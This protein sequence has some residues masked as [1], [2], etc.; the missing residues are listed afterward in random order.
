MMLSVVVPIFNEESCIMPFYHALRGLKTLDSCCIV[1]IVFVNDGS[2]DAS[3]KTIE[4][5]QMRDE[6][7]VLVNF[8]R[9]FGKES[10][11]FAGLE[12]AQGDAVIPIDVDLQDPVELIPE[13]VVRWQAGA[14]IVL[15][16]RSDRTSDSFLKRTSARLY[17]QLHNALSRDK[18]EENVGDFRLLSRRSVEQILSLQERLLF[19]KGIMS[20]VGGRVDVVEYQRSPRTAGASKF[21]A[22]RLWN[23][24]LDGITSFSTFPLRVWTYIGM[25]IAGGALGYGAWVILSKLFWGNAVPGYA[26]LMTVMLFLGGVQLIGI[27]V[28]GEYVGRIFLESKGRPR[29]IIDSVTGGRR[30]AG[31]PGHRTA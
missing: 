31:Q 11:L 25:L 20:W 26:S 16:R 17:Y 9:N 24:A 13:L 2:T 8:S 5:L 23:L 27:G 1:E 12:Y 19:M 6:L 21:N 7:V 15:A 4:A 3:R 10:A 29:Y 14:D 18:I 30:E 28:L 22:W